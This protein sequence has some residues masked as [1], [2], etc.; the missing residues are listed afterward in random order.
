MSD[1]ENTR[2][3]EDLEGLEGVLGALTSHERGAKPTGNKSE[4]GQQDGNGGEMLGG[5]KMRMS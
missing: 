3:D 4:G 5:K 1:G 2:V